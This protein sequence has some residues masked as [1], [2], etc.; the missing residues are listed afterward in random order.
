MNIEFLDPT[1]E[2]HTGEFALAPRVSTLE[3]AIV[4]IVSNGK[5][6][7]VSFFDAFERELRDTHDVA[8]VVRITKLNYSTPVDRSLLDDASRWN[9]LVAGIGD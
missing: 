1:H 6:G 2:N 9:A 3:G 8:E 7:T 5:K 4:A